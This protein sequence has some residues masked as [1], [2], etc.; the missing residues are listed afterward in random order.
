MRYLFVLFLGLTNLAGGAQNSEY[1]VPVGWNGYSQLRF[2]SNFADVNSFAMRRMK[3]WINSAPNFDKHWGFKVQTTITS[4]QNEKFLLQDVKGF[5]RWNQFKLN[6]GQFVPHYSLQRFQHDYNISLTERAAVINSLIPD[7]TLGVR[8]IGVEGNWQNKNKTMELWLGVFNGNGI[9]EYRLDYSGIMLTHKT[10]LYVFSRH[11]LS[12]YSIMYRKADKLQLLK[13]RPE[14]TRFSG[15]DFRY[16]LFA[17]LQVKNFEIQSE[18]L[19]ANLNGKIADGY[20]ILETLNF[21]KNQLITSFNKYNDLME[22]TN[23]AP[24]IHF[25]YNY[26]F[27]QDK[28]K[29]MLDNEVQIN[30]GQFQ[31]YFSALQFQI[32]FN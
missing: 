29:I 18:Y 24:V 17:K 6:F 8:D 11:F 4:F 3:L 7:G 19:R 13:I 15:N 27:N 5:Y 21:G 1:G 23:D 26:L 30:E 10:N 22:S 9:K 14:E 25:A 12:G 32:F 20:Y 2:T 16:N 31:N 28:L